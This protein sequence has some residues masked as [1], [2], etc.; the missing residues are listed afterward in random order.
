MALEPLVG[1]FPLDA[2]G[3]GS[4]DNVLP[5]LWNEDEFPEGRRESRVEEVLCEAC[6]GLGSIVEVFLVRNGGGSGT[7]G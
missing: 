5:C 4:L 3:F 6:S 2:V 1:F 7:L